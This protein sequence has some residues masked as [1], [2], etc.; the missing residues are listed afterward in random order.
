MVSPVNDAITGLP[1]LERSYGFQHDHP[2][3]LRDW[4]MGCSRLR[5][6]LGLAG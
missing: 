1:S 2:R 6:G 3:V 4:V 5:S